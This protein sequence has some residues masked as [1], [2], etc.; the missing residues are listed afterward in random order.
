MKRDWINTT[1]TVFMIILV[2]NVPVPNLNTENS[3]ENE[4]HWNLDTD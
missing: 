3:L 1:Q 4:H 2:S